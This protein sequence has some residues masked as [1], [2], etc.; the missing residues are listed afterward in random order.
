MTRILITPRSFGKHDPQVFDLLKAQGIEYLLN[1][2]GSIMNEEQLKQYLPGCQG[3]IIGVDPLS[4]EVLSVAPELRVVAKYG[5]GTDNI[6][7]SYC[8]QHQIQ[9]SKT[10]GAN[11]QAVA[12]FAMGLIL[13]VARR[14]VT[15]DRNCRKGDWQKIMTSDVYG[16]TL[17][18]IGTGAI[19]RS[20]ARRAAG[21]DMNILGYDVFWDQ[22]WA[23]EH[24]VK[25]A[26]LE[27]IYQQADFISLH[28]PL[29]PETRHMIDA[30]ALS[31]MKSS[32][33]LINTARG[34]LI[35]ENDLLNVLKNHQIGGAGLDAFQ[36]EPLENPEWYELDNV[37]LGSHAAAS[38]QGAAEQMGRMAV[39]NL[40]ADFSRS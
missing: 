25:R 33:I 15:I 37:V 10:I 31:Q 16:K 24:H 5:V 23:D 4:A 7:L 34:G 8:E 38:T 35:D 32:S 11:T 12:D 14:I 9:V 19:G 28:V 22:K 29:L 39:D 18:L 40:I 6:D 36:V 30:K 3:V 17:G 21:F 2:T 26:G 20:V 1:P 13:A 27:E